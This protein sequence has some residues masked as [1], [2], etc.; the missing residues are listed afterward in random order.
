MTIGI[1]PISWRVDGSVGVTVLTIY[2]SH[3]DSQAGGRLRTITSDHGLRLRTT[4][5]VR[6]LTDVC[7]W[8]SRGLQTV[9]GT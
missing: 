5:R 1:D 4:E 9:C 7:G 2:D 6:T 3:D 8:W